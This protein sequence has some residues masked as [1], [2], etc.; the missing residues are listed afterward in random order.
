MMKTKRRGVFALAK[1]MRGKPTVATPA[2]A[3]APA[4]KNLRVSIIIS[5][6]IR[7]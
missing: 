2:A 1:A 3:P 6:R 7:G 5:S 4:R